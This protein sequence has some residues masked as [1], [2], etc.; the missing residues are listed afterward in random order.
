MW[1]SLLTVLALAYLLAALAVSLSGTR[2]VA[3]LAPPAR[4][5]RAR[6]GHGVTRG[7]VVTGTRVATAWSPAPR[8]TGHGAAPAPEPV[9]TRARVRGD[10][11]AVFTLGPVDR[12]IV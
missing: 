6:A 12:D 1:H 2:L 9:V 8:G 4:G 10:T 3:P 7:A 5:T 11:R